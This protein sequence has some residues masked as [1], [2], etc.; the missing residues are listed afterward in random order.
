MT[1]AEQ[2]MVAGLHAKVRQYKAIIKQ[3]RR[4]AGLQAFMRKQAYKLYEKEER[5]SLRLQKAL[6]NIFES[7]DMTGSQMQVYAFKVLKGLGL[8]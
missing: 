3:Q 6:C 1:E 2:K 7:Q 5:V 4:E 8:V